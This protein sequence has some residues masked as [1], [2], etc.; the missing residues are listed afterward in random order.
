MHTRL[1]NSVSIDIG[2]VHLTSTLSNHIRIAIQRT[3]G[4]YIAGIDNS[5]QSH[6]AT[7]K[8]LTDKKQ[9]TKDKPI[10]RWNFQAQITFGNTRYGVP[11]FNI[12]T[13]AYIV[14]A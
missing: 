9:S 11:P 8:Y 2:L 7:D 4:D 12:G 3:P 10:P 14:D 1:R 13:I 5:V 6:K